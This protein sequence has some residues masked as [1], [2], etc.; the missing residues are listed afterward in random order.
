MPSIPAL[1][2]LALVAVVAAQR[3]PQTLVWARDNNWNKPDNWEEGAAPEAGDV[4]SFPHSFH[5]FGSDRCTGTLATCATGGSTAIQPTPGRDT[6]I[7][8]MK[9]LILPNG[10]FLLGQATRINFVDAAQGRTPT[11]KHFAD[12]NATHGNDYSCPANWYICLLYTSPSPR[13]G[14]L[15]RM[16]SSA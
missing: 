14:L 9:T 16:P 3:L 2:L 5:R 7:V 13:D 6:T 10:R 4:V 8:E 11:H 15:S 1:L 12:K